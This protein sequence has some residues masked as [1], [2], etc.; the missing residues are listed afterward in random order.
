MT[1]FHKFTL[2]ELL[3]VIAIIA[4]LASML[5]P[6]LSKAR[7]AAQQTQCINNLKQIQTGFHRFATDNDS[8]I[9]NV[10]VQDFGGTQGAGLGGWITAA[11]GGDLDQLCAGVG[12][13]Y[14]L[15]Y[16][17]APQLFYCPA[18]K[19]NNRSF[20]NNWEKT[21]GKDGPVTEISYPV[22]TIADAWLAGAKYQ[23]YAVDKMSRLERIPSDEP[24]VR[25]LSH[26]DEGYGTGTRGVVAGFSDASVR[27]YTATTNWLGKPL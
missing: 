18:E 17:S 10:Y 19:G 22:H 5:L 12:R 25:C 21:W 1:R 23:G 16:L 9:P 2:I 27:R 3:V 13:L 7:A 8:Y 15:N 6:A 11:G 4:I 14:Y 20:G 24:M 26:M